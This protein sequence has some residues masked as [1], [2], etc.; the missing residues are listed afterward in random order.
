MKKLTKDLKD[1]IVVIDTSA[2]LKNQY[3]I[4]VALDC[5]K[6]VVIPS[7]CLDELSRI[8]DKQ[9]RENKGNGAWLTSMHINNLQ[10]T[11]S[12]LEI[13]HFK[14]KYCR[15]DDQI[16]KVAKKYKEKGL[17]GSELLPYI[18]TDDIDFSLKYEKV[19]KVDDFLNN[20]R[21]DETTAS[22]NEF[23]TKAFKELQ[24]SSWD[25]FVLPKNVNLRYVFPDGSTL[26]INAINRKD[27][28]K[29]KFLIDNG[30]DLNQTD[31]SK[32]FLT[33]VAHCV[34]KGDVNSLKMLL[35]AGAD[36]NKGSINETVV[37]HIKLNNEGN[38]PL[39]IA[40]WHGDEEIVKIL[41]E[42]PKICLNQQDSNGYTAL[43]K[44]AIKKHKV[45]YDYLLSQN[46]IDPLI[47]DRKNHD[48]E[49]HMNNSETI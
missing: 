41:C 32:Y 14:E 19:L 45:I 28:G 43:I 16:I 9:R 13:C 18:L 4:D 31:V 49:W 11:S 36:Y 48:A 23:A 8:K 2:L 21:F 17:D 27:Y 47:R 5:F 1:L 30:V 34:Q 33:P 3:V 40:C 44:A 10:S 15:N 37:S 6:K 42:Q 25:D 7:V 12:K 38:T 35:D 26:L 39:M 20:Y 29:I 46:K 22:K 24:R